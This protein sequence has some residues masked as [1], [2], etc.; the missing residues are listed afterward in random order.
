[1]NNKKPKLKVISSE[2]EAYEMKFVEKL[3][4]YLDN[5]DMEGADKAIDEVRPHGSLNLVDNRD[6][7]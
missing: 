3:F 6:R 5:N 4:Y 7:K 2:R 1:M